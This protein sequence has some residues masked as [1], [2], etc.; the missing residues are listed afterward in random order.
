MFYF[1]WEVMKYKMRVIMF[2]FWD[3]EVKNEGYSVWGN[4]VK[5]EDYSIWSN[6]IENDNLNY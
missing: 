5:G 3:N 4:E 1:V 2:M 6:E